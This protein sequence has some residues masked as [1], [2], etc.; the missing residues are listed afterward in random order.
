MSG[1]KDDTAFPTL[2]EQELAC[3]AGIGTPRSFA[4][5][6]LLIEAGTRDYPFYVVRSGEVQIV[7]SST[8]APREVTVHTAGGFTGDVDIL[9]GRPA[10]I[11]ARARGACEVYEVPASRIRQ[12]LNEVPGLSD[13]LLEAFQ[14]RREL[15]EA[16]GF[17]GIR[18]VGAA[19]S[20]ET[21]ELREFCYKNKVPHT[22]EDIDD[23]VGRRAL[24][25][26]HY[27]PEATP[28]IVCSRR[29][30]SRPSLVQFAECLGI[31]REI[32]DE[33]FDVTIVGAGPA[34]LAAAVYAGSEG[35]K[36]LL[37]D[38]VGPG[39]QTGQSSRI[40]NYLG[41]PA[42][43]R[44]VDLGNRGYLQAMKFGVEFRAPVSVLAITRRESG[45]QALELCN[46][47][48]VRSRAV[49]VATGASYRRLP[50]EGC[51]R[52]E[53]VGVYYAAT[54]VEARVCRRAT[55]VVVGG[56]NSAGQAAM[57]LSQQAAQVKLL[58]RG[59][60]LGKSMSH[61]LVQRIEHTPNIEL[62]RHT[63]VEGLYGARRLAQV[64][65]RNSRTGDGKRFDCAGIFVFIGAKPHTEWLDGGF[66]KDAYGFLRT[67][68]AAGADPLWP[69]DR[70]PC[71]LETTSPGVF[72][73]GDVRSGTTKR[74]AFAV[75]DGALGVTC[76]H[77]YLSQ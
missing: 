21:L 20:K 7:E 76:I 57:Y 58:I 47:Q 55:A 35:L 61:Y 38:R 50:V 5:G 70:Q 17:L 26:L 31:S 37:L 53:G 36:T 66:A 45:E 10:L 46:G 68:I 42:G 64:A 13:K 41:F 15:L 34:G 62:L 73:A 19:D 69:I 60:D 74:C 71:E 52:L 44:G 3:V 14:V 22:F 12:L 72:A 65:V 48:T 11:S 39:G 27:T 75:G 59:D 49:L 30:V 1:R 23:D 63:E 4:D 28:L 18:V 8:G 24:D 67:G 9:T 25:A 33:R 56:G 43:I 6:D 40:E 54:S 2:D 16:T 32:P 51:A 29:V 77:W